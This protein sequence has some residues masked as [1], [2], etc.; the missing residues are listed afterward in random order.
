[1]PDEKERYVP[2]YPLL[3]GALT[4]GFEIIVT[5]PIEHVKVQ[6]QLLDQ[7]P[8]VARAGAARAPVHGESPLAITRSIV[9]KHG[10]LGLYRGLSPWL[11]FA[12][13]RG[14]TRFSVYEWSAARLQRREHGDASPARGGAIS[15]LHSM[16]AGT[17]AGTAEGIF[18]VTPMQNIT[19]KMVRARARARKRRAQNGAPRETKRAARNTSRRGSGT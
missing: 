10:A 14:A 16:I 9:Q 4:G 19:I 1:M 3:A 15:P 17:L 11:F 6:Q 18:V 8:A 13:P 7:A 2:K 12:F 5:Y